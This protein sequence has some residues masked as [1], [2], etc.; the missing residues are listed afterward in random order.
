M[1]TIHDKILNF[2][3]VHLWWLA[4][5]VIIMP[6]SYISGEVLAPLGAYLGTTGI[7]NVLEHIFE[8]I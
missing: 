2:L 7:W 3:D 8:Q 6:I 4:P 5:V 1:I